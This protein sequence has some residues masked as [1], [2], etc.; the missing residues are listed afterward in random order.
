MSVALAALLFAIPAPARAQVLR[1]APVRPVGGGLGTAGAVPGINPGLPPSLF[2]PAPAA[3]NAA[4]PE[5]MPT[6]AAAPIPPGSAY[7]SVLSE[8]GWAVHRTADA[9]YLLVMRR[10]TDSF[11]RKVFVVDAL[12]AAD[13]AAGT[14]AHVDF[15]VHEEQEQAVFDGPMDEWTKAPP[16]LPDG[17]QAGDL[18]HWREHLWFGLSVHPSRRGQGLAGLLMDTASALAR[19]AGAK[20]LV[21]YATDDSRGLYR[22]LYAGKIRDEST[23]LRGDGEKSHRLLVKFPKSAAEAPARDKTLRFLA[24]LDL[25]RNK[26]AGPL[27]EA[28]KRTR[29]LVVPGLFG[30]HVPDLYGGNLRRLA[31]LGL[32]ADIVRVPTEDRTAEGLRR[33]EEAVRASEEPV[34][35][36]GHSRGGVLVH[37][38]FRRAP[39]G[40]KAKVAR[41]VLFQAPLS[42]TT[43]ADWVLGSW[44]RRLVARV[45]GWGY[46]S[47]LLK[48]VRELTPEAR[49]A[50]LASLPPWDAADLA[51]VWVLRSVKAPGPG[52]YGRHAGVLKAMGAHETDGIVPAASAAVPGAADVIL[53]DVD[54]SNTVL[55]NPGVFKRWRGYAP[56][57]DY[58][59]GDITEALLRLLFH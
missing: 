49:A 50:A 46:W 43:F 23:E 15:A 38:W 40:L 27:P 26:A 14:V 53:Q 3:L 35:L 39:A 9:A 20:D 17:V 31:E 37:D 48:T 4:R 13:P 19:G 58:D 5:D 12:D 29:T 33:I 52:L 34:V 36:V 22:K 10:G 7:A 6:P 41:V 28:L 45:L 56:H 25:V 21:I 2:S 44:W 54:H 51:K 30:N 18:S 42:G 57:P 55:A 11:G 1:A 47:S 32:R 8:R 59:V 24:A 16:V